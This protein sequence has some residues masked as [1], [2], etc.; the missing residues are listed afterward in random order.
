MAAVDA[1]ETTGNIVA[2]QSNNLEDQYAHRQTPS[3]LVVAKFCTSTESCSSVA[4]RRR[5]I[6]TSEQAAAIL[7]LVILGGH[8]N[9]DMSN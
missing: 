1:S 3:L 6:L 8:R 7:G 9:V 4:F 5:L 2:T